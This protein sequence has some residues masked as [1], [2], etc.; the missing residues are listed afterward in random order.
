[1]HED[2]RS[3]IAW[4]RWPLSPCASQALVGSISR[5]LGNRAKEVTMQY[6]QP[7]PVVTI[8]VSPEDPKSRDHCSTQTATAPL[9]RGIRA[10]IE[11]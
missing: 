1:M 11:R 2:G 8:F 4:L 5:T 7:P 10:T 3:I 6:E 9:G